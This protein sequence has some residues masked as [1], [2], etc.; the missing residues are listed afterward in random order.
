METSGKYLAAVRC[1]KKREIFCFKQE[2][3][4]DSF[5]RDARKKGNEVITSVKEVV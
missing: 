3:D 1:G 2:S 5:A 4:R